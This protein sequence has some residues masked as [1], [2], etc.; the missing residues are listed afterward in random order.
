MSLQSTIIDA[1]GNLGDRVVTSLESAVSTDRQFALASLL[2]VA[3]LIFYGPE[4]L[5]MRVVVVSATVAIMLYPRLVNSR[6]LWVLF[7]L[8]TMFVYY[9]LW[10]E[11]DNHKIL[12]LVWLVALVSAKLSTTPGESLFISARLLIGMC[13]AMAVA[14]KIVT[15]E[16]VDGSFFR[17]LLLTDI[18]FEDVAELVG[19][20]T[21]DDLRWN[22]KMTR[23]WTLYVDPAQPFQTLGTFKYPQVITVLTWWTVLIEAT[24]AALFL[25]SS[26]NRLTKWR[27][28]ALLVFIVSTYSVAPVVGFAWLLVAMGVAQLRDLS[29]RN[30][31]AYLY[32]AA[33]FWVEIVAVIPFRT[34]LG[35]VYHFIF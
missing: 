8:V 29:H 5:Y 10:Y 11:L 1:I 7:I 12:L 13:F 28:T 6:S 30:V 21:A 16:Y 32:I 33:F 9:D 15:P 31:Y 25:W 34:L 14:W 26:E 17:H 22:Y 20:V 18:R 19:G 2:T 24:V 23:L 3:I 35:R 4:G 27:D